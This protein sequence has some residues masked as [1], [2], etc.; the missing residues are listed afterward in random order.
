MYTVRTNKSY[1]LHHEENI[2]SSADGEHQIGNQVFTGTI[3]V[4]GEITPW[5]MIL[6]RESKNIVFCAFLLFFSFYFLMLFHYSK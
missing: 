6:D 3:Y 5:Q 4:Q 1:I 2:M